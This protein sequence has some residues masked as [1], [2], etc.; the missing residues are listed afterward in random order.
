VCWPQINDT[1]L[2][3]PAG[4]C[5]LIDQYELAMAA[6]YLQQ[7]M[8]EPAVFELFVRHLP[9][10]RDWLLVAGLGPALSLVEAMRLGAAELEFLRLAGFTGPFLEY[11]A[12][13]R[14]SGEVAAM[15]R[16]PWRSPVSH[17]CA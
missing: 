2:L 8:N 1:G 10:R 7:G 9:P 4:A 11:L 6:S 17:S 5:L 3:A 12:D 16:A 13:F 15:P 14:F